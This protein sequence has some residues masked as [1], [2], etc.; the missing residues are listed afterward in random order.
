MA[1]ALPSAAPKDRLSPGRSTSVEA[2]EAVERESPDVLVSDLQMPGR[3]GCW[4]IRQVRALPPERGGTTPAAAS[5]GS[6]VPSDAPVSCV[7]GSSA[8]SR[9]RSRHSS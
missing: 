8:T 1:Q 3:G 6:S 9:S 4:L 5:Q 7:R 2:L